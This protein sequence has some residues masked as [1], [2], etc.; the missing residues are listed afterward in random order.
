MNITNQAGLVGFLLI[1]ATFNVSTATV[2]SPLSENNQSKQTLEGCLSRITAVIRKREKQ[3]P[4]APQSVVD[5]LVASGWADG[6]GRNWVNGR[7]GGWGD[8][9]GGG[10]ANVNPW[11]NGWADGGG[12]Y[13]YRPGW[14]NGG[15][16]L[17]RY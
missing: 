4:D 14:V 1:L 15:G 8:G 7:V 2:S 12:F 9:H 5:Q 11:R 16:F 3:L 13:N 10:F 6:R 17:N